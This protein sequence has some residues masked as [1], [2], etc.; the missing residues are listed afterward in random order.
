MVEVLCYNPA[1]LT[2]DVPRTLSPAPRV[3][4]TPGY[5]M[6]RE[7][8]MVKEMN[9]RKCGLR[10]GPPKRSQTISD[11]AIIPG[12]PIPALNE[13]SS[14]IAPPRAVPRT[15]PPM[16][17]I[18]QPKAVT[19]MKPIAQV[20]DPVAEKKQV[21]HRP[22]MGAPR[23]SYSVMD[24]EPVPECEQ[25]SSGLSFSDLPTELHF[26]I[27]DHLDPIDSTCLGLT[28]RHFYAVHQHFHGSKMPLNSR[29]SGP[30]NSE[31]AWRLAGK[32]ADPST[33]PEHAEQA[34]IGLA[35]FRVRGDV[36]CRKC[37]AC[38]C[39][40]H[41][42]IKEWMGDDWEYCSV[43]EKFTKPAQPG[44]KHNCYRRKPNDPHQCGRHRPSTKRAHSS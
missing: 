13:V 4:F 27:F 43:K 44:A 20:D 6:T 3:P 15:I 26:A 35:A 32:L 14:G 8:H 39:E 22:G 1:T 21:L 5:I 10:R 17:R 31:W 9:L 37:G 23:R 33:H 29:R 42:H 2:Q 11:Y 25:P 18:P 19:K 7:E 12:A 16:P 34:L 38:K 28:S 24:Y 40:L 30:N 41:R 36:Y